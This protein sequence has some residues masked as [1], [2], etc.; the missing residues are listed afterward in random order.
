MSMKVI[1]LKLKLN[2]FVEDACESIQ[3][4]SKVKNILKLIF[5]INENYFKLMSIFGSFRGKCRQ[6]CFDSVGVGSMLDGGAHS[7][8]DSCLSALP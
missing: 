3:S 8:D 2:N 4:L 5:E 7:A 6:K 1:K